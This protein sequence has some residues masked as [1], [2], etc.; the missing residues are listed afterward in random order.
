MG[1]PKFTLPPGTVGPPNFWGVAGEEGGD[2]DTGRPRPSSGWP[3]DMSLK[4]ARTLDPVGDRRWEIMG[5]GRISRLDGARSCWGARHLH[6]V[7]ARR[8]V[9]SGTDERNA[10]SPIQSSSRYINKTD[11]PLAFAGELLL[12]GLQQ[13]SGVASA[14]DPLQCGGSLS[15]HRRRWSK[16]GQ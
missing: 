2:G 9:I 10:A 15:E 5:A 16:E 12:G 8:R 4:L 14:A 6:V 7:H 13:R 1:E 3:V 11:A